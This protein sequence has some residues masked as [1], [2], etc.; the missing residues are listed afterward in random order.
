MKLR[1]NEMMKYQAEY[2]AGVAA[3]I[4]GD[5]EDQCPYGVAELGK[6][7]AWMGGWYDQHVKEQG[8]GTRPPDRSD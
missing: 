4:L 3:Y 8:R 2:D 6:R 5:F 1:P 7:C